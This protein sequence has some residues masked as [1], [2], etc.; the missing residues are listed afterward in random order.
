M[1]GFA[2]LRMPRHLR[3]GTIG[4]KEL[5]R[6]LWKGCADLVV[7]LAAFIEREIKR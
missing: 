5:A 4:L 3:L 7:G 1:N 2:G 6:N